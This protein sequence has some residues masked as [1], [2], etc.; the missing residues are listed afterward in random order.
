MNQE[1]KPRRVMAQIYQVLADRFEENKMTGRQIVDL[2]R[3][4]AEWEGTQGQS[5]LCELQNMGYGEYLETPEWRQKR[6]TA[7]RKACDAC[8]LCGD[9]D[10]PLN[11]HHVRYVNRGRE[12]PEDL[13]VLC[14][15]CHARHH[16]QPEGSIMAV[17]KR[18]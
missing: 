2:L 11:V 14:R 16:D 18:P 6:E 15:P 3:D 17:G 8:R 9:E 1:D 5:R 4:L 10:V 13:I 12:R 7:L